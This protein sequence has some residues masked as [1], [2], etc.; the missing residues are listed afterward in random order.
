MGHIVFHL[1]GFSYWPT[2]CGQETDGTWDIHVPYECEWLL[3][4]LM[5]RGGSHL[6]WLFEG[7]QD[8]H[9]MKF[10]LFCSPS[11]CQSPSPF[12]C[13]KTG[14]HHESKLLGFSRVTSKHNKM[15]RWLDNLY[16]QNGSYSGE[17]NTSMSPPSWDMSKRLLTSSFGADLKQ[18]DQLSAWGWQHG[19][20]FTG[21]NNRLE[22]KLCWKWNG[23]QPPSWV[24]KGGEQGY[25]GTRKAEGCWCWNT[26]TE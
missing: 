20:N 16:S 24:F 17:T 2:K 15:Q 11:N 18:G 23:S 21:H 1:S 22:H 8:E 4:W 6:L 26:T 9:D 14:L 5:K 10:E 7:G 25:Y 19:H 3:S 12:S 13:V